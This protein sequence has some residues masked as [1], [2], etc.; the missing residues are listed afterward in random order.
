[1]SKIT[2]EFIDYRDERF[3]KVKELRFSIL[4]KPYNVDAKFK[5]DPSDK[6]SIHLIALSDGIV[7]GYCRLLIN[8][9]KGK[10]MNVVVNP[11]Y[12]K[13][14]IGHN[15]INNLLEI[16]KKNKVNY[17]YLQ[18]RMNAIVFYEKLGFNIIDR[19]HVSEISGLELQ[20]M[21]INL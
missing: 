20:D 9:N 4:F 14:G 5:E 6:D 7:V 13:R 3:E 10:I 15:M 19:T 16:G 1:M 21:Y 11:H 8:D 17:I 2:Y 18:S 12:S